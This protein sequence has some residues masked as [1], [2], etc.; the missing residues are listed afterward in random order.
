MPHIRMRYLTKRIQKLATLWPAVG[1]VGP[2]QAGKSTLL[3]EQLVLPHHITLDDEDVRSDAQASAKAF[4]GKLPRPILIDEVQKAPKLFD[5]IKSEIDK[6]R[7]PGQIYVTGSSQ[8]SSRIDVR[9]SLTGRLGIAQL[10]PLTMGEANGLPLIEW[11]GPLR[12]A[13]TKIR[14]SIA[15]TAQ[16][17]MRGGMPVPMFF[18]DES[19]VNEYW[20]GWL[21]T[22]IYRDLA[23]FFK[24]AY[25]PEFAFRILKKIS[26]AM[27]EGELATIQHLEGSALKLHSYLEALEMI[28]VLRRVPIH[29]EGVGRDS[30][31]FFDSGFAKYMMGGEFGEGPS[32]SLARHFVWQETGA[33][34]SCFG[35]R[36]E[37]VYYK[38]A[39]GAPI[40]MIWNEVAVMISQK[41]EL[42]EWDERP[43]KGGM[44]KLGLKQ[45]LIVAPTD[46]V[47]LPKKAGVGRVPWSYWS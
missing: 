29:E 34:L 33:Y 26:K 42:T 15:E 18:R 4:L 31:M 13:T 7:I 12:P 24:R 19:M 14:F 11:D 30:Y 8:F 1:V 9:E 16:H 40:D 28:F 25:D 41:S 17:M 21:E 5:A 10:F 43:L 37:R 46:Q 23:R 32:L 6:K 3:R 27:S 38:S 22:T 2:R 44:K 20:R 45:G 39:R 36:D 35:M 47:Y